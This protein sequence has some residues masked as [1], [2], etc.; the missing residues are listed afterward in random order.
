ME[1]IL[2]VK[3]GYRDQCTKLLKDAVQRVNKDLNLNRD[4]DVD[5]QFGDNYAQIH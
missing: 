5:V 2:C 3:K 4:L 1:V